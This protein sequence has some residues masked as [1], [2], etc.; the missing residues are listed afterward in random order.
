MPSISE[1]RGR[2]GRLNF[3]PP[4]R[5]FFGWKEGMARSDAR[6]GEVAAVQ[7][8]L[9]PIEY[10]ID[11]AL[12]HEI[13]LFEGVVMMVANSAVGKLDREHCE[14]NRAELMIDEALHGKTTQI[15]VHDRA[16]GHRAVVV[17]DQLDARIRDIQSRDGAVPVRAPR[18]KRILPAAHA[19]RLRG[20]DLDPLRGSRAGISQCMRGTWR[21]QAIVVLRKRNQ[22]AIAFELQLAGKHMGRLLVSVHAA[23]DLT[24]GIQRANAISDVYRAR[25]TIEQCRSPQMS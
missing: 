23:I 9:A 7:R 24:A 5:S 1:L 17:S 6:P 12:Q 8:V 22:M 14:M 25:K 3:E 18:K 10:D 11:A 2:L 19:F 21:H 20:A 16:L 4:H 15:P 13:G